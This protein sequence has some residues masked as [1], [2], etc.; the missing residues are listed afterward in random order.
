MNQR[1]SPSRCIECGHHAVSPTHIE[2]TAE[3]KHDGKLH[4]VE[5]SD[6][7][8]ERCGNCGEVYFTL[9]S[10]EAISVALRRQLGLLS[11]HDIVRN[12]AALGLSQSQFGS[13]IGAAQESVSRWENG[14]I[15]QSRGTD[16]ILRAYFYLPE[17]REF[18]HDLIETPELGSVVVER[19]RSEMRE[20]KHPWY[21]AA[22]HN[23]GPTW[24]ALQSPAVRRC[25]PPLG[26][27]DRHG[28]KGMVA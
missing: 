9:E 13:A 7:P 21:S 20:Q 14:H 11:P 3:V 15:I 19:S 26:D 18:F 24:A 12:R 4:T 17:L 23:K 1:S 5:V 27:D 8:V 6:L 25:G 16:R 2:H 10:D 22:Q 28:E